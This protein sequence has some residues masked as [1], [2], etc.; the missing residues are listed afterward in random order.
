MKPIS[1]GVAI[2]LLSAGALV[3]QNCGGSQDPFALGSQSGK[4]GP[5]PETTGSATGSDG[6][7]TGSTSGGTTGVVAPRTTAVGNYYLLQSGYHC[8]NQLGG[9][10][11]SYRDRIEFDGSNYTFWGDRCNDAIAVSPAGDVSIAVTSDNRSLIYQGNTYVYL[12]TA[13]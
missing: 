4:S 13:P 9:T 3:F 1:M 11:S 6:S 12:A 2:A 7:Y 10:V 5:T 8:N